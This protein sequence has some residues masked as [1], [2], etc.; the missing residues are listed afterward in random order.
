M[1]GVLAFFASCVLGCA[2]QGPQAASRGVAVERP[3]SGPLNVLFVM[4]DQHHARALGSYGNGF[5][6]LGVS[7]TPH[8]DQLAAEGV[9]FENAYTPNAQCCPARYSLLTGRWPH[10]H[11][12]RWNGIW[13]PREEVTF[14]ELARA[15]GYATIT[16]GKHHMYWLEPRSRLHE[17][18]GFDR[19]VDL[20]DY[21]E[22]CEREAR[23]QYTDSSNLFQMPGLPPD[24]EFTGYTFNENAFHPAGYWADVVMDFLDERA[25]DHRPFVCWYSMI[26][27]HTPILPSGPADPHDWAHMYGPASALTLPHNLDKLATTLR[28]AAQQMVFSGI[29]TAQWRQILSYY[30][31]YVTQIDFNIGRVLQRLE[32]LGLA[33]RT[34]VVY[35]ADHGEMA[36]EMRVWGKGTGPYDAITRV[37]LILRLPQV[38]AA[39]N[40]TDEVVSTNDLVP[41][42]LELTGVPISDEVRARLDGR[43]LLD[44]ALPGPAPAWPAATY[45]EFGHSML[46]AVLSQRAI[47]TKTSKFSYDEL[48]PAEEFYRL[49][50]DP[51]EITNRI[52]DPGFGIQLEISALRGQL[53]AWWND[54][55]GH[56]LPFTIAGGALALPS[57]PSSPA[58]P[59]GALDVPL[60][61]DLGWL[62]STA[63]Q[64]QRLF[65]G[66]SP[67]ALALFRDLGPVQ[68]RA[69]P[70]NLAPS[71][72]YYW[73]VDGENPNGE[74]TGPTWSFTTA[75]TGPAGPG[76]ATAPLPAD[77]APGVGLHALLQ[78]TPDGAATT[79]ELYFGAAAPG[80]GGPPH[81]ATLGAAASSYDPGPLQAG[82]RY[83]WRVD[84]VDPQGITEGDLWSFHT[85]TNG[86]PGLAGDP[87]PAHLEPGASVALLT[88][89]PG[90]AADSH[91]VHL[92]TSFPLA[93]VATTSLPLFDP[94]PLSAGQTYYWRVDEQNALG[95]RQGSVWR[96]RT[97]P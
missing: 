5:G 20:N 53:D 77:R 60:D 40:S 38:L 7:L 82:V 57:P 42:L 61:V 50:L 90:A 55:L 26:G 19:I 29:T 35:T 81:V 95:L 88:W 56:A 43:S 33:D 80:E 16:V 21:N 62:N 15:A 11:G 14:P 49:D 87:R 12:L 65:L 6:G 36:S 69:N 75:A 58:P 52:D 46:P 24:L 83:T 78:W 44:L 85:R 51:F 91:R 34:I 41:T 1:G 3:P 4:S 23:L 22:Y 54:G 63:A 76:L 17:D 86:L 70:G 2:L 28:L 89:R 47:V 96:F 68:R 25:A 13:E 45:F 10:N 67:T 39:G 97:A 8:L 37:P 48:G 32:D 72:T 18:H 92:G 79:Q 27:P 59:S 93:H 9:R 31:G 64:E 84:G 94:G 30:Y 66:T 74:T 73:R 71:T